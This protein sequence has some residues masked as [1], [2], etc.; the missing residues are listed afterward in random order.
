[1]K[2]NKVF[3]IGWAKTGTTTLGTCLSKLG[4]SHQSQDL[5]LVDELKKNDFR[6]FYSTLEKYESFEDWPWLIYYKEIYNA[7]PDSKFILTNRNSLSWIK[8][9]KNMLHNQGN[10]SQKMNEIRKFLYGLDFPLVKEIDLINRYE[11][12]NE[13][14]ERFFEDK[15]SQLLIVNWE[16]GDDWKKLCEFLEKD[17]PNV[18]FP[19]S[20]KGNYNSKFTFSSKFINS[21]LRKYKQ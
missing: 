1:M 12:H 21:Y 14:V 8:S 16:E 2:T 6:R 13:E 20:N 19:H 5:T 18:P 3:G 4:Y 17:I 11:R 10:A 7:Y 9:Y 15:K